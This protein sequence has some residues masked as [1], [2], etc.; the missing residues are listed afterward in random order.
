MKYI[1]KVLDNGMNILMIPM[2][3]TQ[4]V[5]MGFFVKAGSRNEDNSNSGVAHFLEHMM[6]KGTENRT[7]EQMFKELDNMGTVYN[8][9]TTTQYTYYYVYG[10]SDDT[11]KILDVMLDIYINPQF[12]SKEIKKERKVIIE[13]MRMRSDAPMQKLYSIMHKKFFNGTSLSRDI[14]GNLDTINNLK[15]RDFINF[16]ESTYKPENTVFVIS[17]NFSPQPIFSIVKKFLDPLENL[18]RSPVTY[19]TEKDKIIKNMHN[20]EEPYVY[21]KQNTLVQQVYVLLSFPLYD[22]YSYKYHEIDL[23][24]QLLSAGSSSR[25]NQAL[26]EKHGITYTSTAYPIVY[27]DCGLF[28]IQM[29]M[30][31]TELIKGLK[32]LMK[33][34]NRIKNELISKE[35]LQKIIN[36]TKNDMLYSLVK[37][38]DVLTYYGINA[39]Y[40]REFKPNIKKE[41]EN[42]KKIKR[43]QI[44]KIAEDIFIRDRINLFLYGNV[45]ETNFDFLDL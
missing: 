4:I 19:F 9:A 17:G 33:E 23:L 18:P 40:N 13:E 43:P 45:N 37:P 35:E 24:T 27:S 28:L 29:V 20:Q 44:K 12:D 31:P 39:L 22:L 2:K 41:L 3:D 14:I 6:F 15:K 11:K 8:A 21:I 1:R 26:R 36:V 30:N 42:I 32:I 25:L 10:N 34:L 16:R 7:A 38:I 5:S